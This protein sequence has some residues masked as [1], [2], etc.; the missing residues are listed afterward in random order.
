MDK[1]LVIRLYFPLDAL[2]VSDYISPSTGATL[3]A[4]HRIY[5]YMP[6]PH[7]LTVVW[8]Y[9]IIGLAFFYITDIKSVYSAVRTDSL[10]VTQEYFTS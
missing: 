6:I 2:H 8:L 4:V 7:N 10:I 1:I 3:Q 5:R 9:T